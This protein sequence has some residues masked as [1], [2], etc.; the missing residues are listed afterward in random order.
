[1]KVLRKMILARCHKR[2][3][4]RLISCLMLMILLPSLMGG[5]CGDNGEIFYI[6]IVNKL[7]YSISATVEFQR[8]RKY[9]LGIIP[10]DE[11]VFQM[12][13]FMGESK[14]K[15]ASDVISKIFIFSENKKPLMT[16]KGK[17][18]NEYVIFRGN[19][20]EDILEDRER[21]CKFRLEV[22][23]KYM[24]IGLKKG[25]NFEEEMEEDQFEDE[26][27]TENEKYSLYI[28]YD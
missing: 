15:K 27:K 21:W 18:M 7:P 3:F 16:F 4:M 19:T 25:M 1:M 13:F 17:K 28:E 24:G 9:D 2:K 26:E 23:E 5:I 14:T 20:I 11:I 6:E 22:E 10:P 12:Q 8:E